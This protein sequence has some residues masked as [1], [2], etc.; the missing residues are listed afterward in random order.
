MKCKTKLFY[1]YGNIYLRLNDCIQ[2]NRYH[3]YVIVV[4]AN[5]TSMTVG[6]YLSFI[7]NIVSNFMYII[8]YYFKLNIL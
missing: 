2:L 8:Q 4:A 7:I 3:R 1:K 5:T 6:A